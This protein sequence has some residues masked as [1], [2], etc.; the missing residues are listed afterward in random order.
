[1]PRLRQIF[2][3]KADNV[4]VYSMTSA[5]LGKVFNECKF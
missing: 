2:F 3:A 4:V 5:I 1:M